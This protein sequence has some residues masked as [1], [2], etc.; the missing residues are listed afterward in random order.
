MSNNTEIVSRFI[1]AWEA[2]DVDAIMAFFAKDAAYHNMPMPKLVGQTQIREFIQPFVDGADKVSFQVLHSAENAAGTVLNE[3]VD[4]FVLKN[5][6]KLAIKVVGIFE[7][8]GGKIAAWRDYFD[9]KE[10]EAQM[11]A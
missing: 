3:R 10:F 2:R 11:A 8:S 4:S 9:M 6:K 7:L 1:A 5:G